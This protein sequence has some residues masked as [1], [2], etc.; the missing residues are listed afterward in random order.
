MIGHSLGR[1]EMRFW[2]SDPGTL[3]GVGVP[4]KKSLHTPKAV[5]YHEQSHSCRFVTGHSLGRME[6]S[7]F[8]AGGSKPKKISNPAIKTINSHFT[9]VFQARSVA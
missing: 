4:T 3:G 9:F 8:G 1:M 7:T 6:S 2:L 5:T